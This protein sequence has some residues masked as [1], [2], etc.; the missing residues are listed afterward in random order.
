MLEKNSE[1]QIGGRLNELVMEGGFR[2]DTGPSLL[3]LPETY[4]ET[5]RGQRGQLKFKY[6]WSWTLFMYRLSFCVLVSLFFFSFFRGM[7]MCGQR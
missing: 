6:R 4:Q 2:F 1:E 7:F 3:L 5:F